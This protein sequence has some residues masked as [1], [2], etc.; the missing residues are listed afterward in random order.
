MNIF[1]LEKREE[2]LEDWFSPYICGISHRDKVELIG[3][4]SVIGIKM[5]ATALHI[6][7]EKGAAAIH[8][9]EWRIRLTDDRVVIGKVRLCITMLDLCILTT[10]E[11]ICNKSPHFD[12]D[13]KKGAP[14]VMMVFIFFA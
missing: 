5:V 2:D 10:E 1:N 6:F 7:P 11:E 13:V 12:L 8:G 4:A 9:S 3:V 14:Y